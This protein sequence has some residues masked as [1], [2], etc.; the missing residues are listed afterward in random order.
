MRDV[1]W[2]SSDAASATGGASTQS[3][4]AT[5]V[6]IDTRSLQP[7]DLFVAL[8]DM[9]DGHDFVAE[10]LQKGAAA[11]LVSRVPP[12]LDANAPLLQVDDVLAG[13]GRMAGFARARM[14]GKV[15]AITGSVG[16]TSTKEMLRSALVGQ[17]HIHAAEASYNNHWG[18]PLTLARMPAS[19]DYAIVEIGMNHPGEIAP[20]SRLTKPHVV[21]ITTIAPAHLEA[22]DDICGI[23][24]EKLSIV[25]GLAPGGVDI[26]P[27]DVADE[28]R[29]V[30]MQTNPAGERVW[31]GADDR[32]DFQLISTKTAGQATIVS[33][34]TPKGEALFRLSALGDHLALNG[35]AA[36]AAASVAGADLAL[37]AQGLA[38]W[39]PPQ[40]RGQ[41]ETI[42]LDTVEGQSLALIDDAF[43]A[44]PA[45][46]AAALDVLIASPGTRRVAFLGDML[47]LGPTETALHRAIADHPGLDQ[48]EVIHCAGQR[49]AAAYDALPAA[50]RGLLTDTADDLAAQVH[51]LLRAGDVVLVKGSKGAKTARIVDA[52]RKLSHRER[53]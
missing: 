13:L 8:T 11:A 18:V 19:T 48:I 38:T 5:G 7:G 30:F 16:K 37:S 51:G 22:F 25:E 15:I 29:E 3:W 32:A 24:R 4:V 33:L 49:I 44:N 50:Q 17:G 45:S 39:H 1:L 23:A 43:N 46:M 21:L 40:G 9:R 26:L 2:T 6:S 12:G 10:A 53:R 41:R 14:A 28:V 47:E 36:L 35:I 34:I 20:L 52:I 42:I 27:W 31:F